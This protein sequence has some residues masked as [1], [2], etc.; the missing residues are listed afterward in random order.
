MVTLY[1]YNYTGE[2]NVIKKTL[3]TAETITGLMYE[4]TDVL[5]PIV[6]IAS[7]KVF[8]FNYVFIVELNRYYYVNDIRISDNG[9]YIVYLEIDVL[10][11]YQKEILQAK[12]HVTQSENANKFLSNRSTVYDV[13]PTMEKTVFEKD[14][15]NADGTI[16][17]ITVKGK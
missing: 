15:F 7:S 3:P 2:S 14:L 11:T 13:R 17:M 6:K 4:Q 8:D 12:A 1:A 16:I 9:T 10:M 5:K